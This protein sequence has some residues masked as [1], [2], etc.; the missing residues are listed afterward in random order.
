MLHARNNVLVLEQFTTSVQRLK[1]E[2][3]H[4]IKVCGFLAVVPKLLHVSATTNHLTFFLNL[5]VIYC[6]FSEINFST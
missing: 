5:I 1:K 3:P 2:Q 6:L 4:G